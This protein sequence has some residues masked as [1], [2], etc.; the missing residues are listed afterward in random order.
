MDN[1]GEMLTVEQMCK[2]LNIARDTAY[3]IIHR[4]DFPTVRIGRAVRIPAKK[5]EAWCEAQITSAK[6]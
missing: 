1:M 3:T 2:R 5:L 6:M 4:D